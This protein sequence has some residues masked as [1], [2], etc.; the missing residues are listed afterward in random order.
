[1][2]QPVSYVEINTP[3]LP[4][5]RAF[6]A[7]VFGWDAAPFSTPDYLVSAHGDAPGVDTALLPSRDGQPRAVPVIRVEALEPT[8]ESVRA[9]GGRVVVEPFTLPGVG[10][11]C[12]VVDPAGVLLGLHAY[13]PSL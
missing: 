11:G 3:D 8:L 13:D 4:A 5:S 2:T 12:Y 10:K 1:M 6:M 9:H 7:A